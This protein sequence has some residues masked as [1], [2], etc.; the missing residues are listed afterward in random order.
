MRVARLLTIALAGVSL[1]AGLALAVYVTSAGALGSAEPVGR[2]PTVSLA[3]P[4]APPPTVGTT[5]DTARTGT[6]P[7]R[8]VTGGSDDDGAPQTTDDRRPQTAT[9]D[10]GGDD[11]DGN[12]GSSDSGRGSSGSDGSGSPDSG[13]GRG[14]GRGRSGG[15]D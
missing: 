6:A 10:R 4:S 13:R 15:D 1:P 5:T 2:V 12:S 11:G 14:R 9:D 7:V 3:R 8:T